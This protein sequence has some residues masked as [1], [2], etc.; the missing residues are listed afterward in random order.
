MSYESMLQRLINTSENKDVVQ[1]A[2]KNY[3]EL[4]EIDQVLDSTDK[5]LKVINVMESGKYYACIG[6]YFDQDCW[7]DVKKIEI[8][9]QNYKVVEYIRKKLK[10]K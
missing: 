2:L 6:Y 10:S 9:N 1:T 5:Q 3:Q 8:T 4:V 7:T